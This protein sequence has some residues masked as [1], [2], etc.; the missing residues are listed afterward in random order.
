[1]KNTFVT[2]GPPRSHSTAHSLRPSCILVRSDS[3]YFTWNHIISTTRI[4]IQ[5]PHH[6]RK[7]RSWEFNMGKLILLIVPGFIP[8]NH[9]IIDAS[10]PVHFSVVMGELLIRLWW[11][12]WDCRELLIVEFSQF[13]PLNAA[14]SQ[15]VCEHDKK[16]CTG[17]TFPPLSVAL[18]MEHFHVH[19]PKW[20]IESAHNKSKKATI[21]QSLNCHWDLSQRIA[22]EYSQYQS[23]NCKINKNDE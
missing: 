17:R 3:C 8:L 5:G 23:N 19:S 7:P 14:P 22:F 20:K 16:G 2:L 12:E 11:N 21:N 18:G 1:M 4:L 15:T 13:S 10:I 9:C 6:D